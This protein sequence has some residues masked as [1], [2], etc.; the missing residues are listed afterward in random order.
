M[1]LSELERYLKQGREVEFSVNSHSYFIS[2]LFDDDKFVDKFSIYDP[3]LKRII[4][5]KKLEEILS[6]EFMPGISFNKKIEDFIFNY[7]L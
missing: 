3:L 1:I 2:P 7:I 5:I 4:A 6:F